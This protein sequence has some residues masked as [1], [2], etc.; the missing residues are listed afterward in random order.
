MARSSCES[1]R[2]RDGRFGDDRA[3]EGALG[4]FCRDGV[5]GRGVDFFGFRCILDG[6]WRSSFLESSTNVEIS[7]I[8]RFGEMLR[9]FA[10]GGAGTFSRAGGGVGGPSVDGVGVEK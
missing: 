3:V 8:L 4:V 6:G 7:E 1:F 2:I 10:G 9:S 5:L